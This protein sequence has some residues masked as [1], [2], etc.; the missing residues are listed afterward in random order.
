MKKTRITITHQLKN[1]NHVFLVQDP[2]RLTKIEKERI[3]AKMNVE[4]LFI[5]GRL[6]KK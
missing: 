1:T 2:N 5:N 6:Y 4:I 3:M